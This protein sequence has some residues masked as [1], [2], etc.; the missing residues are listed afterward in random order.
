MQPRPGAILIVAMGVVVNSL[1]AHRHDGSS[2]IT[3]VTYTVIHASCSPT[4]G[5]ELVLGQRT[6]STEYARV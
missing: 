3:C 2:T 5:T 4:G 6:M 1:R